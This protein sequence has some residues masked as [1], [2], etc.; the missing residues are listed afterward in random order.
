[1][2]SGQCTF[3]CH[4]QVAGAAATN[5]NAGILPSFIIYT[6]RFFKIKNQCIYN[7]THIS[8]YATSHAFKVA[9]DG[10][11]SLNAQKTK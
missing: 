6:L 3:S 5:Q 9:K 10:V 7:S 11:Y 2:F 1:M 8:F 4:Q